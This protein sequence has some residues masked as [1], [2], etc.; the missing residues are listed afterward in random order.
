MIRIVFWAVVIFAFVSASSARAENITV[1]G[2]M[3]AVVRYE[4]RQ[5]VSAGE[6]MRKLMLSFVVP[7]SFE[8]PTY[9]QKI[10]NFR[11]SFT[12]EA[13]SRIQTTDA[14][15]NTIIKAEW[16]EVPPNVDAVLSFDAQ[17]AAGLAPVSS[18]APFP[19]A[20]FEAELSVYLQATDLIQA[21][22]QAIAD[23]ARQLTSNVKT[24][25]DAVQRVISWIVDHVRYVNLPERYDAL[26]ALHEGKGN[27]QNYSHLA[28]ALL[29]QIGIPVRIVN[30]VTLNAP[31]D[32]A[33]EKGTIT[34]KM[35][36]GRHSWVEIWFPGSGWVPYDPQN[37]QYFVSSR[38]V[39]I[40]VGLD[41][42][43]T[44][45][46]GLVCWIATADAKRQPQL[47]EVIDADVLSDKSR[48]KARRETF[49]P[50]NLLLGPDVRVQFTKMEPP[51]A[52]PPA[53]PVVP[54]EK[55]KV[56]FD[57]PFVAGNLVFPEEVDFAFPRDTR[58]AGR[59]TFEMRKTF[60]VE[61]AEYVTTKAT[62]Y[63]QIVMLDKPAR[64][65]RIALALHKFGGEG[66]LWV[67]LYEDAE[68]SPGKPL[69]TT[70]MI[71][72]DD[73]SGRPG[74][75]WE[76]FSFDQKDLPELMPGAYWIAL[77]FSGSPV[78]NWFYTYG[79]PVG[80]VYGTRYKSMFEQLW[81]GA[82]HYEF[83]YKIEG[84]TV[85]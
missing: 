43:E 15:G 48:V 23:L 46:D 44:K 82:L 16:L 31:F 64:I 45:N 20:K 49:G 25:F 68:G 41:N 13:A 79:K 35:G 39:R 21:Q 55:K 10:K 58:Q 30:G 56:R 70:R 28:A 65:D 61:T 5:T 60:L 27:C 37:M 59:E 17:T 42:A 6:R 26:Y 4:L 11:L 69:A 47:R 38:F 66:W 14:R 72:L 1:S 85:N 7:D 81:S 77:G 75:R 34:F 52:P 62:Q 57:I 83:N 18:E 33:W 36:Q 63:A 54:D 51:P 80:P 22:D 9:R 74:Y 12:P 84:M 32:V 67:D 76:T 73:L 29:R 24:Q 78:V 8:S 2:D 3:E 50:K 71:N 40:E 53:P 19:P